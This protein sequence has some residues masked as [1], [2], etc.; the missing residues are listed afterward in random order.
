M[1]NK[2]NFLNQQLGEIVQDWQPC[3]YPPHQLMDGKFCRLEPLDPLRHAED[4]FAA[5]S[6]DVEGKNW[7][8]LFY[9]PFDDLKSYCAWLE[10]TCCGD[11]PQ[12][13]AIIDKNKKQAVGVASYLRIQPEIGCIEVGHINYS[14]LLQRKPA[15]TEAMYLMMKSIFDLGYRR[16]EWKCNS[17]N[18]ASCA[19]AKRL[20]FTFEGIFRQATISKGRNRDTAWYSIIDKEW[21]KLQNA[22]EQWLNPEN[23]DEFGKQRKSLFTFMNA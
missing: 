4:L 5:N 13:F 8:Y 12:F 6:L 14:P 16:Y 7:R 10:Q 19:A 21:P 2:P 15:A 22:F 20:G 3:L 18:E 23:F 1:N 11:D 9:G 17:L